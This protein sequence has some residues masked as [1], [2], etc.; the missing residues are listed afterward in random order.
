MNLDFDPAA[1][2]ELQQAAEWYEAHKSEL[3]RAFLSE[4]LASLDRI[5]EHPRAWQQLGGDVRQFR[6]NRFPYGI[7]YELHDDRIMVLAIAH[8]HRKPGYWK[9]RRTK[10]D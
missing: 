1:L 10:G 4:V 7:V 8:L 2:A 3:R 6:L 9:R 5:I